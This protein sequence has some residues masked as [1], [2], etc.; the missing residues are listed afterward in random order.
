MWIDFEQN[1]FIICAC[2]FNIEKKLHKDAACYFEQILETA[3]QKTAATWSL[4]SHL[5][6][7]PCWALVEKQ[8]WTHKSRSPVDANTWIHKC[9]LTSKKKKKPQKLTFISSV[10]RTCQ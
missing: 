5:A 3:P 9:W 7:Y 4:T 2:V 6:N 1:V 10:Q 8:R